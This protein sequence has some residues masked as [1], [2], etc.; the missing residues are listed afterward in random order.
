MNAEKLQELLALFR[1]HLFSVICTVVA[2][3]ALV[4]SGLWWLGIQDLRDEH[5]LKSKQ[6]TAMLNLLKTGPFLK[7]ELVAVKDFTQRLEANLTDEDERSD[8]DDYFRKM[9]ARSRA[10]LDDLQQLSSPPLE[11]GALYKR[12]PFTAR[13][14]GTYPQML[15][16]LH[17]VETGP[18]L[19]NV[20]ALSLLR[21]TPTGTDVSL[22]LGLEL[23]GKK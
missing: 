10:R 18:R 8:N 21:L 19:A 23:I 20:T 13:V 3:A 17:A 4:L 1:R 6:N 14:V 5:E 12:V 22:D 16:F 15:A 11:E 9:A 2:L 7:A